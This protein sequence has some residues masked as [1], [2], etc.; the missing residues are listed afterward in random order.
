[1]LAPKFVKKKNLILI[2]W[3]YLDFAASKFNICLCF[4]HAEQLP[5][6]VC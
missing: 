1:M 4:R 6:A 3:V 2:T 5:E